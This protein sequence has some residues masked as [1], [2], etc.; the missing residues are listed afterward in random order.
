MSQTPFSP[1]LYKAGLTL[2]LYI[3]RTSQPKY[4]RRSKGIFSSCASEHKSPKGLNAACA[5][6]TPSINKNHAF[7]CLTV[8]KH[9][10]LSSVRENQ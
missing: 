2:I 1:R 3:I 9:L 6:Q 5:K 8:S 4:G 7:L 10:T